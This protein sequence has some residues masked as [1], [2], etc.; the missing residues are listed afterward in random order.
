[1]T[2]SNTPENTELVNELQAQFNEVQDNLKA[3]VEGIQAL[4]GKDAIPP[5]AKARYEATTKIEEAY[6]WLANG[7]QSMIQFDAKVAAAAGEAAQAAASDPAAPPE[8]KIVK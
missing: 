4:F 8:L 5:A 1:M 7:V 3:A 6:M 2:D